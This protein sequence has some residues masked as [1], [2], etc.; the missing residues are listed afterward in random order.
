MTSLESLLNN[1]KDPQK[2][3]ALIRNGL[4][5]RFI[6]AF[7]AKEEF[8][9]ED[10][11]IRLNIPR[12]TFFSKKK[13]QDSYTSEKFIRLFS[14]LKLACDILGEADGK[15]WL[16]KKIPS[17]NNDL[18]INLLD[19]ETGHRLVVQTLIQIKYGIYG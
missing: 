6:K 18:P 14:V 19:T 4:E 9:V 17:L 10:V 7:L 12:S 3:V 1:L 15:N 5:T 2:E 8:T 11:L 16:Y 13:R